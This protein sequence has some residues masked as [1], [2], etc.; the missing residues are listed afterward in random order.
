MPFSLSPLRVGLTPAVLCVLVG[1]NHAQLHFASLGNWGSGSATQYTV[2]ALLKSKAKEHQLSFIVSPGSNF[3]DGV[4]DL[5][6]K[7]W[8]TRFQTPYSGSELHVPFF[9]V[10][11]TADW[12][13]NFTAEVLKTN[14]TDGTSDGPRWMLPNYW[15]HYTIH[16][17]D[18]SEA[19]AA[20]G[21]TDGSA[22]FVFVDTFIL[23]DKFPYQN[24]TKLHWNAL[25][26][27]VK[28]AVKIFDWVIVVGDKAILSSGGSKGDPYLSDTL[29]QLLKS[30]QVDAYVSG[31]DYD[32]EIIEDGPLLHVNCGASS[33]FDPL[34]RVKADN[35][36][37]YI[38]RPG[39]CHHVLTKK[40]FVTEFVDGHTGLILANYTKARNVRERSL[41]DRFHL[42]QGLPEIKY[43]EVP[44][45]KHIAAGEEDLFLRICGTIGLII[46]IF[47]L[48]LMTVTTGSRVAKV[49]QG[50]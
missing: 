7:Y 15:Y 17:S 36:V 46:L 24:I 41:L 20:Y 42:Y 3:I 37:H 16:F 12:D 2:G 23:S 33:G 14:E 13:S 43:V 49:A 25:R 11:G 29:R 39:F 22:G 8:T 30:Y 31:N 47:I 27:T 28:A 34:L 4:Q 26:D 10:L 50:R 35:S 9:P 45:W 48:S 40:H 5:E 21:G 1:V 44:P 19:S 18:A 6:D 38:P 32:M